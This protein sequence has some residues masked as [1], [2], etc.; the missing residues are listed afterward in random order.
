MR[1][2]RITTHAF[3]HIIIKQRCTLTVLKIIIVAFLTSKLIYTIPLASDCASK[4]FPAS[5]NS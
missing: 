1:L 4:T 2:R 3:M 5:A